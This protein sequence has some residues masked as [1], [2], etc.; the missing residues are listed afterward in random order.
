[1]MNQDNIHPLQLKILLGSLP[2][3]SELA[4]ISV[5]DANT[6]E[7]TLI[8]AGGQQVTIPFE[9]T[10]AASRLGDYPLTVE[11]TEGEPMDDV[12]QRFSELYDFPLLKDVDYKA[13][14]VAEVGK[15]AEL[16]LLEESFFY[17][18]P[19]VFNMVPATPE[20][21][22]VREVDLT[23]FKKALPK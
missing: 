11:V 20:P 7:V 23:P 14:G 1:M 22:K 21:V 6:S 3:G 2:V 8:R 13:E 10:S 17:K 18:G 5:L 9:K 15:L 16:Q 12:V 4:G 19:L